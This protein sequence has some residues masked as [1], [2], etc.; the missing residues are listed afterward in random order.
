[1]MNPADF[2]SELEE[3]WSVPSH[4]MSLDS[5]ER[6]LILALNSIQEVCSVLYLLIL[7]GFEWVLVSRIF[8]QMVGRPILEEKVF[9]FWNRFLHPH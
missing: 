9:T 8:G 4:I 6:L 3:N 5:K 2:T 7:H 1:M